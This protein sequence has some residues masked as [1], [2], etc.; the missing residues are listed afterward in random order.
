VL[1]VAAS[2]GLLSIAT[3]VGGVREAVVDERTGYVV[4]PEDPE[5]FAEAMSRLVELSDQARRD[6]SR[7]ARDHAVARFD[8]GIVTSE[9][10]RLYL[11]Y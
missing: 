6:M 4:P 5:A 1:I 2:S 3:D 10:E 7:A 9:W 11:S 8:L